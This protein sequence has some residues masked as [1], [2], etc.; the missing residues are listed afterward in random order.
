MKFAVEFSTRAEKDLK[1]IDKVITKRVLE[2]ISLLAENPFLRGAIKLKGEGS[3]FRARV[4]KYRIL[5]EVHHENKIIL[6]VKVDKRE[7]VYD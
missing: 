1:S 4:G 5:Y 6:I 2:K 7:R 3:L